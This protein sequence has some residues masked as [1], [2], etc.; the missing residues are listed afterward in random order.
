MRDNEYTGVIFCVSLFSYRSRM[1]MC[2]EVRYVTGHLAAASI[3]DTSV[4]DVSVAPTP[5]IVK[6]DDRLDVNRLDGAH[7]PETLTLRVKASANKVRLTSS[8]MR[9]SP[10]GVSLS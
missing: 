9:W 5:A 6:S 10:E 4:G 1:L 8:I 7:P 2:T 3:P